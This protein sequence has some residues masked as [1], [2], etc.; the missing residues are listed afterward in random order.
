MS[1]F[2]TRP[3][4]PVP[5]ISAMLM[6]SS[7]TSL[8]TAGVAKVACFPGGFGDCWPAAGVCFKDAPIGLDSAAGSVGIAGASSSS[9]TSISMR[10]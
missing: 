4:L 3:S 6:P 7:L 10:G 9:S 2:K 5:W 8:L 1:S